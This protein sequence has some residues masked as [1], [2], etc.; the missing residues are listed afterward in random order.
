MSKLIWTPT[1]IAA[2]LKLS[3]RHTGRLLIEFG[4]VG[5]P[6]KKSDFGN[7]RKYTFLNADQYAAFKAFVNKKRQAKKS[8][9]QPSRSLH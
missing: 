1:S 6:I 7:G 4:Y 5:Q 9:C 2:D 3:K 8:Y